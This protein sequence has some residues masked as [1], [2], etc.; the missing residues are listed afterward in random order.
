MINFKGIW[1]LI[2][3]NKFPSTLFDYFSGLAANSFAVLIN[4]CAQ[5]DDGLIFDDTMSRRH[6]DT[7]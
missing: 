6:D 2:A 4:P 3:K 7:I 5:R 1:C